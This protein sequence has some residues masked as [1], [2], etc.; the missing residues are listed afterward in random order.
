M[1]LWE[2]LAGHYCYCLFPPLL[3]AASSELIFRN[4]PLGYGPG[5]DISEAAA[6]LG[7]RTSDRKKR[8]ARQNGKL[9]GRPKAADNYN[10]TSLRGEFS[11]VTFQ[12]L[13]RMGRL[14]LL[15]YAGGKAWL[16]PILRSFVKAKRPKI[17]VEAFAGGATIGLSLL[18]QDL[19]DE[20]VMV[21][22]DPRVS[23]FWRRALEDPSFADE[24]RAFRC[25]RPNVEDIA[26]H[27]ERDLAMWVLVKN[28]C[29][30]GGMLDSGLLNKGDGQGLKSRWSAAN[31]YYALRQV[32]ALSGRITLVE[33]DG[34]RALTKLNSP[35]N[36][37]FI[38]PPYSAGNDSPGRQ[39]YRYHLVDYAGLFAV[40]SLW[41]GRWCASYEDHADVVAMAKA[42][43]FKYTRIA[44][45][46]RSQKRKRELLIWG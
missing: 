44:M 10:H 40:L 46:N 13:S 11:P 17:F 4:P 34:I 29:G 19:V 27:P 16:L 42:H 38:D 15:R 25:T 21:E 28:R 36:A 39:L 32:R 24:V 37:A 18:H 23:A 26:A 30:F 33:G 20:L 31:L 9:G 43:G 8:T 5:M 7:G 14:A 45:R 12:E 35:A 41:R 1:A 3:V 22:R 6:I 2:N